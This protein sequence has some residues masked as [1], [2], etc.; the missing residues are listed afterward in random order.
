MSAALVPVYSYGAATSQ[1]S[2]VGSSSRTR[3]WCISP[4]SEKRLWYTM[5]VVPSSSTNAELWPCA[6]SMC[7]LSLPLHWIELMRRTPTSLCQ[8]LPMARSLTA[9]LPFSSMYGPVI[10]SARN[11]RTW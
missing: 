10:L 8:L 9:A 5:Y 1:P 6:T 3:T 2:S 4:V 11:M 7:E